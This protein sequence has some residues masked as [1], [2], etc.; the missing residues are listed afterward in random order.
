[1][2]RCEKCGNQENFKEI[3]LV[4]T[5]LV[6]D[7]QVDEKFVEREDVVC[8]KCKAKYSDGFIEEIDTDLCPLHKDIMDEITSYCAYE[9]GN[10]MNCSEDECVL[11]RIEQLLLTRGEL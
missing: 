1:M 7:K 9:C 2:Y 3:N 8:G 11:Y 10:V 5:Y 4:A 6:G